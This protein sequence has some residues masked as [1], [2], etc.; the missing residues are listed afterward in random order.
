VLDTLA[1]PMARYG[2]AFG[3]LL[4]AAELAV[5]GAVEVAIAGDPA[6]DDTRALLAEVARSFVPNL[7]LAAG[8]AEAATR[9]PLL[10]ERPMIGGRATAYVCRNYVCDAPV[11]DA[12][13]LGERLREAATGTA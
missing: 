3:Q 10:R 4:G 8:G 11:T 6:R 13:E 1:E 12:T 2:A 5:H 7:V 9:V